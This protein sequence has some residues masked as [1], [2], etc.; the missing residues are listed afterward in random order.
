M[1][2][3]KSV[4]DMRVLLTVSEVAARLRCSTPTIYRRIN[5]GSIPVV[6]PGGPG[7]TV[8]IP[9]DALVPHARAER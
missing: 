3:M 5:D 6:Q 9:A 2:G 1:N 8:R 4:D 7:T